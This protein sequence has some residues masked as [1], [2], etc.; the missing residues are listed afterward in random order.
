VFRRKQRQAIGRQ[1]SKHL[2]EL[3]MRCSK[4]VTARSEG[5]NIAGRGHGEQSD[6]RERAP[7]AH[8]HHRA[9]GVAGSVIQSRSGSDM[10]MATDAKPVG[11]TKG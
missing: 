1:D 4:R 2:G 8:H 5:R 11:A 9:G 7:R 10:T 6:E 3:V